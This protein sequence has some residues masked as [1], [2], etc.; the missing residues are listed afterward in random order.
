MNNI[1]YYKKKSLD[2]L[3]MRS[4]NSVWHPCTQIKY[5]IKNT[6]NFY[7]IPLIPISHGYGPW[8]IDVLGR[9]Y[10]DAISS[11]WVNLFGHS[12]S[13]INTALK[14]Q[15]NKLEHV[16]LS[17]LTHKPVIK[18]SEKLSSFTKYKLGHCF[19][20]SDGASAVEIA[21]KMSFHFWYNKGFLNKKKFICL[22]NSY[23]GETLGA[24]AVTNIKLFKGIYKSLLKKT[25]IIT[26]PDS[27]NL[28][29]GNNA[30]EIARCAAF[31]L[32]ILLKKSSNKIAAIIIEPLVQCAGGMI[33]YDSVYLK[34][35]R[36]I[37]NNYNIHLIADE[38]AVGCGRTGKF[39]ACEHADIWPDFL[40][41]SKGI[42]GGYLPLSLV[43]TTDKIYN[44]IYYKNNMNSFLHSHSY[45]GNPLACCAALATLEIFNK[46]NILQRISQDMKK[47]TKKLT[48]LITHP[49]IINF[50]QQGMIWAFDVII[51]NPAQREIFSQK[52]FSTAL[53]NELLL[54]P[55]GNTVYLMPPY[56]LNKNEIKHMILAIFKTFNE[57]ISSK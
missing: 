19:Y 23:H 48:S 16:M 5:P 9:R 37:C 32:E 54:R 50:R 10:L 18:L 1:A 56:I 12:N 14:N 11:W 57:V 6:N 53:K 35:V 38:I 36:E 20:S 21:L 34:L 26:T 44:L 7:E 33:M 42:T 41:L 15:L 51:E 13:Y 4:L 49:Q 8:L 31:D 17:N 45:S 2:N 46:H 25:Y 30:H 40:C 24:L 22:Q 39:F 43:M 55:I 27:R 3:V 47:I 29:K 28:N 52:F